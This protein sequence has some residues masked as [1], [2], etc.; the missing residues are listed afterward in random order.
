MTRLTITISPHIHDRSKTS[1]IMLDVI[2]A[3]IPALIAAVVFFGPRALLLAAV[4]ISSSVLFELIFRLITK[5]DISSIFDLSAVVTG[6]ILALCLPANT[7]LLMGILA[8]FIAIV[9]VKQLFG[10]LGRNFLNPALIGRIVTMRLI[11]MFGNISGYPVAMSWME[12][13]NFLNLDAVTR[14]TPLRLLAQNFPLPSLGELFIGI[15][16]GTMGETSVLALFLGGVYLIYRRVISP[17]I[18]LTFIGTTLLIVTIAGHD[19]LIHLFTGSLVLAAIFMATDYVT[20][21]VNLKG[22]VIFGLG[23]GLI[24]AIVRLFAGPTEGVTFAL[25]AMNI[26][27]P[28]IERSTLP[29]AFGQKYQQV[30][31]TKKSTY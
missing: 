14:A 23:C 13:Y 11:I 1:R 16:P 19:P 30:L 6:F 15:H 10:G 3:L 21:P 17:V 26:L 18:P 28:L 24:T 12:S 8:S 20:S 5:R 31:K 22:R 2:I 9:L 29:K 7:P 25:L 27:T 4:I